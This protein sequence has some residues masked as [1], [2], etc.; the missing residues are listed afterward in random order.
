MSSTY[1]NP[2]NCFYSL[3][4]TPLSYIDILYTLPYKYFKRSDNSFRTIYC[5]L[6]DETDKELKESLSYRRLSIINI[7]YIH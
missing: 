6:T 1:I 7:S 4:D 2:D 5:L 3:H